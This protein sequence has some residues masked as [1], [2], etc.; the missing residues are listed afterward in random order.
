MTHPWT[1]PSASVFIPCCVNKEH[2]QSEYCS[3]RNTGIAA[4]KRGDNVT[5]GSFV[6]QAEADG[7]RLNRRAI[8]K[9]LILTGRERLGCRS[10]M[11]TK[12]CRK[13][14]N[15][16]LQHDLIERVKKNVYIQDTVKG[17]WRAFTFSQYVK[18][19]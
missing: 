8:T 14:R 6:I 12:A 16:I 9:S 10:E 13:V 19:F 2:Q 3:Y 18:V 17:D 11:L 4:G 7:T 1:A 5:M 15:A